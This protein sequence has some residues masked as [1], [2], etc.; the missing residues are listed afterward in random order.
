MTLLACSACL[1]AVLAAGPAPA[2]PDARFWAWFEANA[3]RL[4]AAKP[5]SEAL[6]DE[7][8]REL[9]R[10]APGLAFELGRDGPGGPSVFVVSADG[11]RERFPAVE[12]FV[13]AAPKV[14]GWRIVAF[15]QRL[16]AFTVDLGGVVLDPKDV[17][18]RAE[19]EGGIVHVVVHVPGLDA[20]PQEAVQMAVMILLDSTVGEYDVE[21]RLGAI[22]LAPLP[23][24]PAAAGLKPLAELAR[25]VDE[26]K[27]RGPGR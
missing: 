9:Q 12:R 1:T 8:Q 3:G 7:V 18:F 2:T 6:L 10:A 17:W 16:P 20:R 19:P 25:V 21:T 22:E 26:A 14:K 4:A 15:R 27:K 23:A 13:A 11:L 5:P 24:R